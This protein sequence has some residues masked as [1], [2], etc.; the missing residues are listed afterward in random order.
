MRE[1]AICR[2]AKATPCM[3]IMGWWPVKYWR[4]KSGRSGFKSFFSHYNLSCKYGITY[5]LHTIE[6]CPK[7]MCIA[8]V[9]FCTNCI[10]AQPLLKLIP[11]YTTLIHL[12]HSGKMNQWLWTESK[13]WNTGLDVTWCTWANCIRMVK[14]CHFQMHD[15]IVKK[16]K[17]NSQSIYTQG[18]HNV[19]TGL[20]YI[21]LE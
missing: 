17:Q 2:M 4:E 8:I 16:N 15:P 14:I 11:D 7:C 20:R 1:R 21:Q 3:W 6:N 13:F 12:N 5:R 19:Y 10:F 9:S 18:T